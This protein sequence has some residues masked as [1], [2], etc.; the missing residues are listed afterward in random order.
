[1]KTTLK[2]GNTNFESSCNNFFWSM[3]FFF[4]VGEN[5]LDTANFFYKNFL[6]TANIFYKNFLVTV[7][8]G[9]FKIFIWS[10]YKN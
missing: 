5:F 8:F 6:F 4:L 10:K 3:Q 2:L 1:M 9:C 7:N